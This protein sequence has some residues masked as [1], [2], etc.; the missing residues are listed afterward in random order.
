MSITFRIGK[1]EQKEKIPI[2]L[3]IEQVHWGT[4]GLS[5]ISKIVVWRQIKDMLS[6]I[7]KI[8]VWRQMKENT[9]STISKISVWRQIK[10]T[11]FIICKIA[12]WRQMVTYYCTMIVVWR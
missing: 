3:G 10:D 5:T 8:V 9:L 1:D 7:C 12:V 2:L 6:T 4:K 11:L